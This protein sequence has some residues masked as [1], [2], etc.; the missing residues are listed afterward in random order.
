MIA[1]RTALVVA[2]VTVALP[3]AAAAQAPADSGF[4]P[5]PDG[6]SFPN[7]GGEGEPNLGSAEMR[8]LFGDAVCGSEPADDCALTPP[9]RA[10]M[11]RANESMDG[12]HCMGLSV[13]AL[14]FF[15]GAASP[16]PFGAPTTFGLKFQTPI[17][18]EIAY[19]FTFQL[20]DSVG[21]GGIDGTPKEILAALRRELPNKDE[22]YTIAIFKREFVDGHA[23]TPYA[24]EDRAGGK[25]AI[26]VYD[27]NF[28]NQNREVI[29]DT[30]ADT[31]QYNTAVNPQADVDLYE[32]DAASGTFFLYPTTPGQGV[33]PCTF[34]KVVGGPQ[35]PPAVPLP[36]APPSPKPTPKPAVDAVEVASTGSLR[37]HARV[38]V[39]DGR[40]TIGFPKGPF[41]NTF[42]SA[43]EAIRL[44]EQRG[45]DI[46]RE[47]YY[48]V[49]ARRA[50]TITLANRTRR[51]LSGEGVRITGPAF[52]ASVRG[53]RL[54][55]GQTV[56]IRVSAVGDQLSFVSNRVLDT[57]AISIGRTEPGADHGFVLR[58]DS[59]LPRRKRL[60]F[61]MNPGTDKLQIEGANG[62][63]DLL[64]RRVDEKGDQV[65]LREN[66]RTGALNDT[67][68]F[69]YGGWDGSPGSH[70]SL[71]GESGKERIIESQ[72]APGTD[73]ER[74]EE[75][76]VRE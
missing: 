54:A 41:V 55:K 40:R 29:I 24:I 36:P 34:C 61:A 51:G 5:A 20:L 67:V 46:K 12:G 56:K 23:I 74:A 64:A 62:T 58:R 8:R 45:N 3:A 59:M 9:A 49:P 65:L 48:R 27:N 66:I 15:T 47:P 38:A 43:A 57:S 17:A 39:S 52:D 69:D 76:V 35:D 18:R 44:I 26:K 6:F 70:I 75:K 30:V 4:R 33:Q 37:R 7:Y 22:T 42:G 53:L 21:D 32:G 31:F 50:Y 19:G 10:W 14:R 68:T 11:D 72:V 13:A 60:V 71:E 73:P 63:Y 2:I 16:G 25:S 28:P 1:R